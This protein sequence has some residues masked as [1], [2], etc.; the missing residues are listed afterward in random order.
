MP[1][2]TADT[3]RIEADAK[4]LYEAPDIE[5]VVMLDGSGNSRMAVFY[6]QDGETLAVRDLTGIA[7][8]TLSGY[9]AGF[10]TALATV[11]SAFE[12]HAIAT[13]EADNS[14][15]DFTNS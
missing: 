15:S 10:T 9:V 7:D 8:S 1:I 13:L 12:Q 6:K 14:G 11:I 3:V 4:A 5:Y 2:T